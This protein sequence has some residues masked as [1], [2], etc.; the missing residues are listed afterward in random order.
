MGFLSRMST[1]MYDQIEL[2][3]EGFPALGALIGLLPCVG[4]LMD[5]E[6]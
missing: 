6:V 2:L 3:Q 5:N 1:M 4:L